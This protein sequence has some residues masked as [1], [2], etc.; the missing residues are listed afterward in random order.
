MGRSVPFLLSLI[1]A[2]CTPLAGSAGAAPTSANALGP[3]PVTLAY[4]LP[5][6]EVIEWSASGSRS[7]MTHEQVV[8]AAKRTN[9]VGGAGIWVALPPDG[10]VTWGTTTTGSKFGLFAYGTG[11]V[12]AEARRVGASTPPGFAAEIGTPEQGYGPPGFIATGLI[13]PENGCWE[14]TYRID[15]NSVTFVVNVR[16]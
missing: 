13:F 5:P 9:W 6:E 8:E 10:V 11:R 3:C 7:A 12:T 14:V 4:Q 1:L 15:R 2:G 16:P